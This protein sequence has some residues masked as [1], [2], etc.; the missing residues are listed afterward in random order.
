M[1]QIVND[2]HVVLVDKYTGH[3]MPDGAPV[4]ETRKAHARALSRDH[5]A[6]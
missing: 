5:L 4:Q 6:L 3:N 1:I 2:V